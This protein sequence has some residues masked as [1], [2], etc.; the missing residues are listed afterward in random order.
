MTN[1]AVFPGSFDPFTIG[2]ADIVQRAL[3]MFDRIIIAIGNN[4][5]KQP[6]MTVDE[7]L[8]HISAYY[9]NEPKIEVASY[10]GLTANFCET[11]HAKTIIRGL[12]SVSD[13]EFE[14]SIAQ[15]NNLLGNFPETVFLVCRPQHAHISSTIIRDIIRNG[16]DAGE[17]MI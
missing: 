13:F 5:A 12:R 6:L 17:W 8:K 3:P 15:M 9:K 1:I 2:H 11:M 16:G 14:Q 7:R 4:S 10:S